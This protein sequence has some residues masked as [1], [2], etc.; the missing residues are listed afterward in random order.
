MGPLLRAYN[1]DIA[2]C[3]SLL[4]IFVDSRVDDGM[5]P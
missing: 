4:W 3:I 1:I 2:D 5:C